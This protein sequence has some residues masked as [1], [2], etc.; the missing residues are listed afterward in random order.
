MSDISTSSLL[1][2]KSSALLGVARTAS[3]FGRL[4]TYRTSPTEEEADT[5]AIYRDWEI[6]GQDISNATQNYANTEKE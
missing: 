5:M 2:R 3:L 6:V 4:D 1:Y